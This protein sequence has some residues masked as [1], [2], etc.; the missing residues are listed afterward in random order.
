MLIVN[1]IDLLLY[2]PDQQK[3]S[4]GSSVGDKCDWSTLVFSCYLN[5]SVGSLMAGGLLMY[6]LIIGTPLLYWTLITLSGG[7]LLFLRNTSSLQKTNNI[8]RC[9]TIL[10]RLGFLFSRLSSPRTWELLI[11]SRW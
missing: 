11:P 2:V 1:I 10:L 4:N 6:S 7:R 3:A 5:I 8:L 9:Q